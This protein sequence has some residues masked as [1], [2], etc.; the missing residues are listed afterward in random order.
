MSEY[1]MISV[2]SL[3]GKLVREINTLEDGQQSVDFDPSGVATDKDGT[4]FITD[5]H[6]DRLL[7]ADSEGKL[8]K[9]VGGLGKEPAAGL[10]KEPHGITLIGNKVYVCDYYNHRIQIF[11]TDLNLLSFFGTRGCNEGELSDPSDLAADEMGSIYIA[12]SS[13]HRVQV[14]TMDGTFLRAFHRRGDPGTSCALKKPAGIHVHRK[15]VYVTEDGSNCVSVFT[16]SGE[17]VSSFTVVQCRGLKG[18]SVDDDGYI[19]L[20]DYD[21]ARIY[22]Y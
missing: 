1:Y 12:D 20:C 17:F 2:Y 4:M 15:H 3:D 22:V 6:S 14:F 10:F 13:N 18:V 8:L 5:I 7:K 19:Y 16:T 9:A 11:D 21:N